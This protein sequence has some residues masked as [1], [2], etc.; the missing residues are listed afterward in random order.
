MLEEFFLNTAWVRAWFIHLVDGDDHRDAGSFRMAD[1]LDGLRHDAVIRRD[2]ENDDVGDGSTAS[3]HFREGSVPWGVDEGDLL[4]VDFFLISTDGLG[5]TSGFGVD[6]MRGSDRVNKGGLAVVDVS[7]DCDDG[8][9]FDEVFWIILDFEVLEVSRVD[10]FLF[11]EVVTEFQA[12]GA[13]HLVVKDLVD[14]DGLPLHKEEFDDGWGR[15]VDGFGELADG[16]RLR[17]DEHA[18]VDFGVVLLLAAWTVGEIGN[19]VLGVALI[20]VRII[21]LREVSWFL[22]LGLLSL[23]R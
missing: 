9:T 8:W 19:A 3:A 16:D 15:N 20:A 21:F 4:A 13:D 12:D 6:D 2:D 10:D 11:L 14:R 5:D 22:H 17:I 23:I 18:S 7:H 1:S